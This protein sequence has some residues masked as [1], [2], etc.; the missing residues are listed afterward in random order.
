MGD[1]EIQDDPVYRYTTYTELLSE[2]GQEDTADKLWNIVQALKT[3]S[4]ARQS[5]VKFKY[6]FS[7]PYEQYIAMAAKVNHVNEEYRLFIDEE[8]LFFARI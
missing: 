2:A 3:V 7:I 5:D 6:D 8:D 1:Q 4:A